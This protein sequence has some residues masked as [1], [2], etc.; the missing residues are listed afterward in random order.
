MVKL[1]V[2]K[3][4]ILL[5]LCSLLSGCNDFLEEMSQDEIRPSTVDDM[6]QLLNG[7]A[8]TR[9]F[10]DYILNVT[11]IFTDDIECRGAV[12]WDAE[13]AKIT[14]EKVKWKFTWQKGM[15]DEGEGGNIVDYWELPYRKIKGC[16]VVLDYLDKVEGSKTRKENLRGEALTLRAFYYLMLVNFFGQP[17]NIGDPEKNLGVPLKLHMD[18]TEE[19]FLRNSVAEVY[20]CIESDLLEGNRL[21]EENDLPKTYHRMDHLA[22]KALL[23]RMYLYMENWDKALEYA[24][25]VLEINSTLLCLSDSDD[26]MSSRGERGVYNINTP[27]EIIWCRPEGS[28]L[29]G[30]NMQAYGVSSDLINLFEL[31]PGENLRLDLRYYNY[32]VTAYD[33][34]WNELPDVVCKDRKD[35]N[36]GI[37]TAEMY[38]NRAEAYI[39]KYLDA[40]VEEYR[41]KA[42]SDLNYL[43][44][45]RYDT[46]FVDYKD[47]DIKDGHE[48]LMFYKEERR[49]ELCGESNHRWFDLRRY[50]ME[51]LKHIY[52]VNPGE[53]QE[54]I[55]QD[56]SPRYVLPIPKQVLEYNRKLV[57]NP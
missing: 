10:A 37:R 15:F 14:L 16:N 23:S 44:Q 52:F 24:D 18:V 32:F 1:A 19:L 48:L 26:P 5:L 13:S 20:R 41:L 53:E 57:Q 30:F 34:N 43:R 42:L 47:V 35:G 49:R 38:L 9:L 4:G 21:L 3:I 54:F 11:E 31:R 25:K 55:L 51:E 40:G 39:H 2:M 28:L 46:R 12:G 8:Y 27:D 29:G 50:G 6:E 56:N 33:A 17:Y 7:E 36:L 22:A 45:H